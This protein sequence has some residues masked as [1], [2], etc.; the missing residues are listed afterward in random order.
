MVRTILLHNRHA[1]DL[2]QLARPLSSADPFAR[3]IDNAANSLRT[4]ADPK[5]LP[6]LQV[7]NRGGERTPKSVSV[8]SD[9]LARLCV[10]DEGSVG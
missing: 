7:L 9:P 6:F 1:V 2:T 10:D 3:D 4:S 5:R 8:R